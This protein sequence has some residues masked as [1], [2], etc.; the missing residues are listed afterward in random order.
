M[1]ARA[2]P[3]CSKQRVP[4]R[5]CIIRLAARF[6]SFFS[7]EKSRACLDQ[8]PMCVSM[9]PSLAASMRLRR[10]E[11]RWNFEAGQGGENLRGSGG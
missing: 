5:L 1:M 10:R 3:V 9:P 2:L 6:A 8:R 7:A 11:W 4:F